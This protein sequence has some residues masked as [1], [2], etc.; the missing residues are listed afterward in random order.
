M[1]VGVTPLYLI[2]IVSHQRQ[3]ESFSLGRFIVKVMY[4]LVVD[5]GWSQGLLEL[6]EAYDVDVDELN[7]LVTLGW[8]T[9]LVPHNLAHDPEEKVLDLKCANIHTHRDLTRLVNNYV[10]V[11]VGFLPV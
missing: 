7:H 11:H 10:E 4:L 5:P 2:D 8:T 6:G 3:T 1:S 9:R